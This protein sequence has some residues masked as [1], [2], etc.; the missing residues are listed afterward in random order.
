MSQSAVFKLSD[1]RV[2]IFFLAVLLGGGCTAKKGQLVLHHSENGVPIIPVD[3]KGVHQLTHTFVLHNVGKGPA[4]VDRLRCTTSTT[5][6]GDPEP[7][8]EIGPGETI[9]IAVT[10]KSHHQRV[11]R[12][13]WIDMPDATL[14]LRVVVDPQLLRQAADTP[15]PHP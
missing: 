5:V 9:R 3:P 11:T 10:A 15:L 1:Q 4:L 12:R 8:C 6:V 2:V 13:V 14:E 7:P